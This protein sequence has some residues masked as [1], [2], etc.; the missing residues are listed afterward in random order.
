M[1]F[2]LPPDMN[3]CTGETDPIRVDNPA[4]RL[5]T[6]VRASFVRR[7]ARGEYTVYANQRRKVGP[8]LRIR[9]RGG[10]VQEDEDL[11]GSV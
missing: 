3:Q 5:V 4:L 7:A 8:R 10:G 2:L 11:E 9:G 1:R 6:A